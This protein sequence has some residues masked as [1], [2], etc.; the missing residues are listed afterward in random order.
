MK[1]VREDHPLKRFFR[2]LIENVFEADLG[3]CSPALV[4]YLADLLT[5]FIHVDRL[6]AI[7]DAEGR[8][9]DQIAE[10]LALL[11]RSEHDECPAVRRKEVI[12][13]HIGD[14]TLF[15]SGLYPESL[16]SR[17]AARSKDRLLDYVQQGKRSYAIASEL[18]RED[19]APPPSLLRQLSEDFESCA[20]GLELVRREWEVDATSPA[21]RVPDIWY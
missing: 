14:Y 16:R 9:L 21:P 7:R 8:P 19:A 2:G 3:M 12:Y 20:H 18:S 1:P 5:E 17:R 10:M 11:A 15:W 13:R 6:R 4:E